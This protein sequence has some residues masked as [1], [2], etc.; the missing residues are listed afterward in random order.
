MIESVEVAETNPP[1]AW[2]G[3]VKFD[4]AKVLVVA[5][6]VEM[7]AKREVVEAKTPWVKL[8]VVDVEFTPTSKLV[9][10]V[11]AK[12][13]PAPQVVVITEPEASV[14]R[15]C[16]AE[17]P[18]EEMVRLVVEARPV[19]ES[20]E[21]VAARKSALAKCE[22]VEAKMPFLAQRA[23]VVAAAITL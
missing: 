7:P 4:I 23:E 16:P 2:S 12:L 15:H 22:V 6:I 13:P 9:P 3:P 10:G 20:T 8:I 17:A 11:K 19:T 5:E 18:R 21:E 1:I 14:V